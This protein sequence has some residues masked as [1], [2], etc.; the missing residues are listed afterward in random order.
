MGLGSTFVV[1]FRYGVA[2]PLIWIASPI[3]IVA[4]AIS[5]FRRVLVVLGVLRRGLKLV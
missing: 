1:L 2:V 5:M 4:G 3:L